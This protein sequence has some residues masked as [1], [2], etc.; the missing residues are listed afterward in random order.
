MDTTTHT[1]I[2]YTADTPSTGVLLEQTSDTEYPTYTGPLGAARLF[3]RRDRHL[4]E[5]PAN[6]KFNCFLALDPEGA[7]VREFAISFES[8]EVALRQT[9]GAYFYRSGLDTDESLRAALTTV[10]TEQLD[11]LGATEC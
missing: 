6:G 3:V 9:L 4:M 2:T 7:E 11:Q 1:V 5:I 10:L 8:M